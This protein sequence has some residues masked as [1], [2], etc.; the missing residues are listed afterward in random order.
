MNLETIKL[1]TTWNDA[2][3]SINS[4]FSKILQVLASIN[5]GGTGGEGI[6]EAELLEFLV[7]NGYITEYDSSID[8]YNAV[9]SEL[10]A[11]HSFEVVR[12]CLWYFINHWKKEPLDSDE[13][14]IENK[15]AYFRTSIVNGIEIRRKS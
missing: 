14:E 3:G 9:F 4:N 10:I 7:E 5:G 6:D 11:K 1:Q 15:F 2:A 13:N 12:S 8:E